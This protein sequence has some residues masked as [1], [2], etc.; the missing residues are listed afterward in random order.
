MGLSTYLAWGISLT[1]L[2]ALV[3]AAF[4]RHRRTLL[5]S[6]IFAAPSG[7]LDAIFVPEYWTPR[8]AISP[9]FS[10]EGLLFSFGNGVLIWACAIAPHAPAVEY[11]FAPLPMLR[12]YLVYMSLGM[13][14]FLALWRGGLGLTRLP[15][16]DATLIVVMGYGLW[17]LYMEPR[18]AR[19]GV[20]GCVGFSLVYAIE[21]AL[22]AWLAPNTTGAWTREGFGG[23]KFLGFPLQELG[24]AAAYGGVWSLSTAF[25]CGAFLRDNRGGPE[26]R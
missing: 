14:L 20:A 23:L 24:W 12:R 6:G 7:L 25:G 21:L 13:V 8:H 18:W 1:V 26:P 10:I 15:I 5:L 16:M 22:I 3:A 19:F 17:F 2:G 11:R 9:Y 4:R